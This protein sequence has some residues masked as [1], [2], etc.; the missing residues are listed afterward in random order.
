M[1]GHLGHLDKN[2]TYT[3]QNNDL[4][5]RFTSIVLEVTLSRKI[6]F[7]ALSMV[8]G[9]VML[10]ILTL[11]IILMPNDSADKISLAAAIWTSLVVFLLILVDLIP[12]SSGK[13]PLLG[14]YDLI[15]LAHVTINIVIT[16]MVQ[17][18]QS[19]GVPK[20]LETLLIKC[21]FSRKE[22][23]T[24]SVSP[25]NDAL[26]REVSFVST[27]IKKGEDCG[28]IERSEAEDDNMESRSCT[29]Q[30]K[31]AAAALLIFEK[32]VLAVQIVMF[33]LCPVVV[34]IQYAL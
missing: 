7:T 14:M 30:G 1:A 8:V 33:G 27:A 12:S 2:K 29:E 4:H 6:T 25:T 24:A 26:K 32:I 19:H 28:W 5:A 17:S 15:M 3:Y 21:C 13:M 31:N 34:A 11:L 9:C 20:G 22:H 10:V 18:F 16:S 23:N